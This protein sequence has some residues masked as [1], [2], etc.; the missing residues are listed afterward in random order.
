M[1][2]EITFSNTLGCQWEWSRELHF[3]PIWFKWIFVNICLVTLEIFAYIRN[4]CQINI[5]PNLVKVLDAY[6]VEILTNI[7]AFKWQHLS[8]E[9]KCFPRIN[10]S[11]TCRG[12]TSTRCF[13]ILQVNTKYWRTSLVKCPECHPDVQPKPGKW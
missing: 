13:P 4:S 10:N 6:L 8:S 9:Q 3:S 1:Y 7:F 12:T 2:Q 5:T 11:Q